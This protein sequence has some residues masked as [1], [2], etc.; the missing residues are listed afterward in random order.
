GMTSLQAVDVAFSYHREQPVIEGLSLQLEPG[1]LLVLVGGNGAGKTTLLRLLAGQLR[2]QRG[3]VLLDQQRIESWS[4]MEVA[5]RVALMPQFEP[6]DHGFSVWDTVQLGRSVHR[7]WCMPFN[8]EDVE[9]V[10]RALDVAG[11][12]ELRKRPITTLSGGQWRRVVLA[13][14]LAQEAPILLLDEPSSGL[15]LRHQFDCLRQIQTIVKEKHLI[16]VLTL[17]DLNTAAMFA[18]QIAIIANQR[19]LALGSPEEVLTEERI[20]E[21]FGIHVSVIRDV[22]PGR[23]FIVPAEGVSP[24]R[25]PS[26]L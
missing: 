15:D 16:A 4:R 3:Q 2:A 11:I 12:S 19:L 8:A 5:R 26:A 9:A 18:D 7:G 6:C 10:E 17:H 23:P 14:S 22:V 1:S 25:L 24:R 13:R 21:A 20:Q